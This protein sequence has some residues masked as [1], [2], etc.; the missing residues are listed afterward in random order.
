MYKD[1]MLTKSPFPVSNIL[2]I[3]QD[4]TVM[5]SSLLHEDDNSAVDHLKNKSH[6]I[7]LRNLH[8][9]R[10]SLDYNTYSS[11]LSDISLVMC[12]WQE[13]TEQR[14]HKISFHVSLERQDAEQQLEKLRA[15]LSQQGLPAKVIYSGGADLDILPQTASKG[16]GLEFLLNQAS[17]DSLMQHKEQQFCSFWL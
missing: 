7:L 5:C 8:C 14:P 17:F 4:C 9:L 3:L 12:V 11:C 6:K 10:K 16:K 2:V 15:L 1:I 13:E